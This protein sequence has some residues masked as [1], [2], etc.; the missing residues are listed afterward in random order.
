MSMIAEIYG[1]SRESHAVS[2]GEGRIPEGEVHLH[3]KYCVR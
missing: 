2:A 1:V 3:S